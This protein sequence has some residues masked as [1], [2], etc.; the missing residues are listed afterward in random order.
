MFLA[1]LKRGIETPFA[2]P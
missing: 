2:K 1:I